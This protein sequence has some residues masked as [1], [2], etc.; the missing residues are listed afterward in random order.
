M[1]TLPKIHT[2][3]FFGKLR[4]LSECEEL[5]RKEF[6][7]LRENNDKLARV[8]NNENIKDKII[9]VLATQTVPL[10]VVSQ[11]EELGVFA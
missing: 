9:E 2:T 7:K 4:L 5:T 11:L 1:T 3:N 6:I 10:S 8:E